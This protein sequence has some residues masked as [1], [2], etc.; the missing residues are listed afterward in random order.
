MAKCSICRKN[1]AEPTLWEIIRSWLAWHIFPTD[2]QE[3]KASSFTHGFGDG[4]EMGRRQERRVVTLE[5][6]IKILKKYETKTL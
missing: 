4:Y 3:E 1:E 2:L 6:Q 5:E